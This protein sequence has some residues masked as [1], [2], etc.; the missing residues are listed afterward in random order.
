MSCIDVGEDGTANDGRIGST[1]R[2]RDTRG[3]REKQKQR[4]RETE[5]ERGGGWRQ[6]GEGWSLK[7]LESN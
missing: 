3:N 4:E 1:E 5:R 7:V 6:T 2:D